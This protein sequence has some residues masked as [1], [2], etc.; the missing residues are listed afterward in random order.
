MTMKPWAAWLVRHRM[1]WVLYVIFVLAV[2]V[3]L[4]SCMAAAAIE[5]WRSIRQCWRELAGHIQYVKSSKQ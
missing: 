3:Y 1:A 5:E 2:P 4:L